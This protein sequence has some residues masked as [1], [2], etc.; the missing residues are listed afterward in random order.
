MSLEEA[1]QKWDEA[2]QRIRGMVQNA[3]EVGI[4][5]TIEMKNLIWHVTD[6]NSRILKEL[7]RAQEKVQASLDYIQNKENK[8]GK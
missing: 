4:E 6:L 3:N 1:L 7:E 5:F 8:V 2:L